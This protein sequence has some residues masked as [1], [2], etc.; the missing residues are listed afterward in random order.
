MSVSRAY[1][2]GQSHTSEAGGWGSTLWRAQWHVQITIT[3]EHVLL[4]LGKDPLDKFNRVL[5][6]EKQKNFSTMSEL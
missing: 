5:K 3:G 4:N 1:L 6:F 2:N